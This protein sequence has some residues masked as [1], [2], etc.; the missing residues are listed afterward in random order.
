MEIEQKKIEDMTHEEFQQH[1]L[2]LAKKDAET[3]RY[4]ADILDMAINII[5]TKDYS[6]L[7]RLLESYDEVMKEYVTLK[8][9]TKYE[10]PKDY[11]FWSYC[12]GLFDKI[13]SYPFVGENGVIAHED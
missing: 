7:Y 10:N 6:H 1:W 12:I 13:G 8:T 11:P 2:S 4:C 3:D 9:G 5:D